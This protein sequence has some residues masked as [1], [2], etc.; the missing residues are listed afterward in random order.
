[1]FE[2]MPKLV[3][4]RFSINTQSKI[5]IKNE[6]LGYQPLSP[7]HIWLMPKV[8][9]FPGHSCGIWVPKFPLLSWQSSMNW[10]TFRS[11]S[12]HLRL[13]FKSTVTGAVH[14]R[15]MTWVLYEE[16]GLE[17]FFSSSK[18]WTSITIALSATSEKAAVNNEYLCVNLDALFSHL[19]KARYTLLTSG[20]LMFKAHPQLRARYFQAH[21]WHFSKQMPPAN[22]AQQSLFPDPAS[23][24]LPWWCSCSYCPAPKNLLPFLSLSVKTL[25]VRWSNV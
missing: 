23:S 15:R 2:K 6:M 4:A 22:P 18:Y 13:T 19:P 21:G 8:L 17:L 1:M 24:L 3:S 12:S 16:W 25:L 5:V 11:L 10:D 14:I 7:S 9:G 20:S